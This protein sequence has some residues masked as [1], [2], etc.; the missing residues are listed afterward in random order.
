MGEVNW[1]KIDLLHIFQRG[2]IKIYNRESNNWRL[3]GYQLKISA[4]GIVFKQIAV[5]NQ[6]VEQTF[7]CEEIFQ[8]VLITKIAEDGQFLHIRE[9]EVWV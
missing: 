2:E 4:D 8:F 7:Q 9:V 3:N 1:L 6:D 5:L